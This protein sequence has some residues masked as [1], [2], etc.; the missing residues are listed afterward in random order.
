MESTEAFTPPFHLDPILDLK[1]AAPLLQALLTRRGAN[2]VIDASSVEQVG[3]LCLQIL[4][5]AR[6]TWDADGNRLRV[7]G[8]SD[9]VAATLGLLGVEPA[10]LQTREDAS[11]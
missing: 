4:L 9:H 11:A 8:L 2:L 3:G 6:A 1:A 7:D 10:E 5:S